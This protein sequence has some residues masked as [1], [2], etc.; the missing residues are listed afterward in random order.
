MTQGQEP[1]ARPVAD[2]GVQ[3]LG[4]A[5]NTRLAK[6][7]GVSKYPTQMMLDGEGKVVRKLEGFNGNARSYIKWVLGQ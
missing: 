5:E 6:A 7:Y 3:N 1:G 2:D 4:L